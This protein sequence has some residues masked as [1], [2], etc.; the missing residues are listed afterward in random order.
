MVFDLRRALLKK[1]EHESARLLPSKAVLTSLTSRDEA[2]F[3]GS[4]EVG[5]ARGA[6]RGW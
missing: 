5:R 1:E 2:A 4:Y 3:S 6:A